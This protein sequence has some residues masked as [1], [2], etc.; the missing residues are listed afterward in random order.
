M[1]TDRRTPCRVSITRW[2]WRMLRPSWHTNRWA[3]RIA[4]PRS[5]RVS[6]R[7]CCPCH[8]GSQ[9][10]SRACPGFGR[11]MLMEASLV[12][13]VLI[14]AV[15]SHLQFC[16]GCCASALN[17]P[18]AVVFPWSRG[19]YGHG[20]VRRGFRGPGAR[21]RL[22]AGHDVPSAAV[23]PRGSGGH[24]VRVVEGFP[25]PWV[26]VVEGHPF[27]AGLHSCAPPLCHG[28]L[29]GDARQVGGVAVGHEEGVL[30]AAPEHVA[31]QRAWSGWRGS[32][33]GVGGERRGNLDCPG[34]VEQLN[35]ASNRLI[36]RCFSRQQRQ[37][38]PERIFGWSAP[39]PCFASPVSRGLA[40]AYFRWVCETYCCR[41][42][43]V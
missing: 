28:C 8:A 36:W 37:W 38:S 4:L 42:R 11:S 12:R 1:P 15:Y 43:P 10:R 24:G 20:F 7:A 39:A 2:A 16:R 35:R 17:V 18:V 29:Q 33:G 30:V 19:S 3:R 21:A 23:P 40:G 25:W 22:S 13:G 14:R 6:G 34:T 5:R 31:A 27:A 9:S 41:T 26:P 32:G